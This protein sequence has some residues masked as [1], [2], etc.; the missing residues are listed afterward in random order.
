MSSSE[1]RRPSSPRASP[2]P[3]RAETIRTRA[4]RAADRAV[5]RDTWMVEVCGLRVAARIGVHPHEHG[6][7]QPI[8]VDVTLDMSGAPTPSQDRLGETL[9]YQAVADAVADMAGAQHVQ[10][11]ETLAQTIAD[12]CLSDPR[13]DAA[14]VR[15]AKPEALAAAQSAGCTLTRRRASPSRV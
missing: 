15:I 7:T 11:V 4:Q 8:I 9:D 3:L 1:D 5:A 14:T 13:V 6:R 2:L 10:L 12:W